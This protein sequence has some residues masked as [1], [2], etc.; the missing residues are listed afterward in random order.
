METESLKARVTVTLKSGV[1]DPQGK[2]IEGALR[3]LSIEG[4]KAV[5]QGKI[6]EVELDGADRERARKTLNAGA[7]RAKFADKA[8]RGPSHQSDLPRHSDDL[9]AGSTP[10]RHRHPCLAVSSPYAPFLQ[11]R[12][13]E[14]ARPRTIRW[15]G[16]RAQSGHIPRHSRN[17]RP[18][19]PRGRFARP[20]GSPLPRLTDQ[21]ENQMHHQRRQAERWFIEQQQLRFRHQRPARSRLPNPTTSPLVRAT[22]RGVRRAHGAAQRQAKPLRSRADGRS[23]QGPPRSGAVADRIRRRPPALRTFCNQLQRH[24][25]GPGG[26]H[27]DHPAVEDRSG[28]RRAQDRHPLRPNHSLP[29]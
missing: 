8:R 4:V 16:P 18:S 2:A 17:R 22:M 20:A 23:T 1:L 27:F 15:R 28:R 7:G 25:P 12:H 11:G 26:G 29:R 10:A 13:F 3:S 21:F 14:P 24:R 19:K 5:R 6:F 9:R